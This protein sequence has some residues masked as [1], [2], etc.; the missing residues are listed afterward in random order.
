MALNRIRCGKM[1]VHRSLGEV[2]MNRRL[3]MLVAFTALAIA[4]P[5]RAAP[6]VPAADAKA[7][8]T[9]IEAQLAAF[10]SDDANRAFSFAAPA[11]QAMFV[12]PDRF[13]AMVRQSYPVVYR[14]AAVSFLHPE[15]I[16]GKLIQRVQMA[17]AAGTPWLVVYEVERQADH[18]WRIAGC[19]AARGQGRS[20]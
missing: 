19:V 8:R 15:W 9:L 13:L 11:I 17:D 6:D 14:P 7:V 16:D 5:L 1:C 4:T 2:A 10:A 3:L 20:T 12:N 18:S